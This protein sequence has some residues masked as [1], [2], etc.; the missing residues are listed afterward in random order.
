[1]SD[2]ADIR[3]ALE[4]AAVEPGGL[5][6]LEAGDTPDAAIVAGHLAGCPA[7]LEELARLRRAETLLRPVIAGA[8]DPALRE[9]TLA[10]VREVGVRRA[11]EVTDPVVELAARRRA[12]SS[13][14]ARRIAWGGAVAAALVVGLV[15]G[16]LLPGRDGPGGNADPAT[17]LAAVTRDATALLAAGDTREVVL[18]DAT[19]TPA[20]TLLL[21]PSEGRV[22]VTASGLTAPPPGAEHRCWVESGG[23]RTVLGTMWRAGDVA[24]WS[25]DVALPAVLPADVVYGVSLVE[26]GSAGPGSEVLT[27]ALTE[28]SPGTP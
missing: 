15:G 6:R 7:C 2:H 28:G 3:A 14:G 8:P 5:D 26:A 16:A 21:S 27:G 18:R 13:G 11:G 20:G 12:M 19:G 4:L 9:R 10:F 24:W 23:T 25:G 1:M 17:A 22:V